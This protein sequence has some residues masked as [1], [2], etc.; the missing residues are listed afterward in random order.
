M[1]KKCKKILVRYEPWFIFIITFIFSPALASSQETYRFERMWPTL[2]QPW[3]VKTPTNVAIDDRGNIY[4]S[5]TGHHR[6]RKFNPDGT[7]I[8]SW[9][10]EGYG[11]GQFRYPRGITVD[12]DGYV[13]VVDGVSAPFYSSIQKRCNI[14]IRVPDNRNTSLLHNMFVAGHHQ[15]LKILRRYKRAT[16]KGR[17]IA[18]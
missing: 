9:G 4:V 12:E 3:Y 2:K 14:T 1:V 5:D 17:I 15:C 6:I 16:F 8:T 7:F 11:E 18:H 13:Y 10:S